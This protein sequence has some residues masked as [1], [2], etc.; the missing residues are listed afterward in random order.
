[1]VDEGTSSWEAPDT[2]EVG[3]VGNK[4]GCGGAGRG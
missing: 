2:G 4:S 3:A 1:M